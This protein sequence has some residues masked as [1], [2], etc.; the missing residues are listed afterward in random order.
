MR[1]LGSI[2]LRTPSRHH[3]P[4]APEHHGTDHV[5]GLPKPVAANADDPAAAQPNVF[6]AAGNG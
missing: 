6:D 5:R 2:L 1:T 4:E 3:L